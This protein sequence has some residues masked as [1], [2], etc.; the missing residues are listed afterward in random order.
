MNIYLSM[1]KLGNPKINVEVTLN[2]YEGVLKFKIM[3]PITILSV[4]KLD[5]L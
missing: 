2:I 3:D 1:L 4:E 5:G